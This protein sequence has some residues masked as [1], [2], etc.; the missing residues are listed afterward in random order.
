MRLP[1]LLLLLAS[2]V[3]AS[4]FPRGPGPHLG[5]FALEAPKVGERAPNFHLE[6]LD[7]KTVSL[8]DLLGGH[9]VLLH[10][11]SFSCPVFRYRQHAMRNLREKY[12]GRVDFYAI[13]TREAHPVGSPSPYT[14]EEWNTWMNRVTSVQVE[15]PQ[16]EDQRI[17]LASTC[18]EALDME[19]PFLVDSMDNSVW[20]A[21]GRASSP[22]F[23]LD[24]EGT[25]LLSQVW[26]LPK[27]IERT[28]DEYFLL[29]EEK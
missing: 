5:H 19:I 10:F 7:G 16:T 23:L 11:G 25:L 26:V 17:E 8:D 15:D 13:Y 29:T 24:P 6:N 12:R 18:R 1:L 2:V 4:C 9:P 21:Y 28:L 27:E 3:M 20:T 22:A 14:G